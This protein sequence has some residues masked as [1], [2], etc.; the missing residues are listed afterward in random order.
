MKYTQELI[1]EILALNKEGYSSRSIADQLSISKSGVNYLLAREKETQKTK[2]GFKMVFLDYETAAALV[3]TFGRFKQNIS[4]D[5]VVKEGG[6]IIC[7]G[8][9]ER[10]DKEVT[11]VYDTTGIDKQ[12]D[13]FIC[14]HMWNVY[15][16]AD[17]VVAHNLRGFDHKVLEARCLANGLPP[18]P[19][20]KLID[21]LDIAKKHYRFPSNKLDSLAAYLGIGR[22][23]SHE[24]MGL[25]RKTQQG[26]SEALE[27]MLEY[28]EGDVLLLEEV[29]YA[30][31]SRGLVSSFNAAMY[32]D[33][34][35]VR[36]SI[37]GSTDVEST[38]RHVYTSASRFDEM[39][40]NCCN[41]LSRNRI[42]TLS[43]EKRQSLLSSTKG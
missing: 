33:D 8:Y 40:C 5:A 23:V 6:W 18:L 2:Q 21:T 28:N 17:V 29:F 38:G 13:S 7:A 36:C 11:V 42:N 39:K 24:G 1:E 20:V 4:Q 35:E 26:D 12:D 30:L 9:K 10:L 3:Y 14:K 32:Y 37:C 15:D 25:W 27:S 22:K 34:N 41:S 16:E 19:T 43:K 31:A